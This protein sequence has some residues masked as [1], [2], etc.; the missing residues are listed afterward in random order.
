MQIGHSVGVFPQIYATFQN[1]VCYKYFQ[2]STLD[3]FD[4]NKPEVI[5]K[6]AKLIY[7]FNNADCTIDMVD[8]KGEPTTLDTEPKITNEKLKAMIKM[9][10]ETTE[11]PKKKPM[12]DKY[13]KTLTN[14]YCIAEFDWLEGIM[15]EL[16]YEYKLCHGD[17]HPK[18]IILNRKTGD[19]CFCDFEGTH[20]NH[21]VVDLSKIFGMKEGL[22]KIGMISPDNPDV[23]A[24]IRQLFLRSYLE[25]QYDDPSKVTEEE[26]EMM[27]IR[28]TVMEIS[29]NFKAI[30]FFFSDFDLPKGDEKNVDMNGFFDCMYEK[31]QQERAQLEGL[32]DRYL[33]LKKSIV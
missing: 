29:N 4:L 3:Y 15:K 23:T 17:V 30:P 28:L 7:K 25:G 16:D 19:M 32:L 11:N 20:I 13:R 24:D 9:L 21:T 14:D 12:F 10:P 18:N 22:V 2:G 6:V 33:E 27:D 5:T 1:G 31:Y 26:V 8:M